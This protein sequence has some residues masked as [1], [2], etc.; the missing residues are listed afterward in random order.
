[1]QS[2]RS[3]LF[4]TILFVSV[5]LY[6]LAIILVRPFG[7]KASYRVTTNWARLNMAAC[8]GL[9]GLDYSIEGKEHIPDTNCVVFLKHSSAYETIA[10]FLVLPRQTWVLKRELI[11]APFLGWALAC[12]HPI[13]INRSA[14]RT[15]VKQVIQQGKLRLAEGL[16]VMIFP[17]GTRMRAGETR[18]YGVSGSL[19]AQEAGTLILPIAHN[20]GD[21]WPRRGWRKFPG[22][23]RFVIGPPFDPKGRDPRELNAEIQDWIESKVSELRS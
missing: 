14:G 19:L 23:V 13:A 12:L 9:C 4:T 11:W 7:T 16:W 17:E 20:A 2:L 8:K 3:I 6:T 21:F 1:M 10:Q 5:L 22:T 15:A 18:R